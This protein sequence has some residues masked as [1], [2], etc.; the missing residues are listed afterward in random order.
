MNISEAV[1]I[2]K[3]LSPVIAKH[4][5]LN[6]FDILLAWSPQVIYYILKYITETKIIHDSLLFSHLF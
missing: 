5:Q 4:K 2:D 1:Y 6:F 3:R